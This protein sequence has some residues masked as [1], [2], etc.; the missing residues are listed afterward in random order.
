MPAL[1]HQHSIIL[2]DRDKG[3]QTALPEQLPEALHT[4]CCKHLEKAVQRKGGKQA[5]DKFWLAAKVCSDALFVKCMEAMKIEHPDAY[6]YLMNDIGP[7][8]W[9]QSQIPRPSWGKLATT[10]AEGNNAT[11][12]KHRGYPPPMMLQG[13]I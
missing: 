5:L 7:Q 11:H 9:A 2:S 13:V 6:K 3:L 4:N 10:L 1:T 12:K 8:R